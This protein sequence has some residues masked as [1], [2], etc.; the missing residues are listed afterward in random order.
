MNLFNANNVQVRDAGSMEPPVTRD[1]LKHEAIQDEF[2]FLIR[3]PDTIESAFAEGFRVDAIACELLA[4]LADSRKPSVY[5]AVAKRIETAV[6]A[7][8]WEMA[9]AKVEGRE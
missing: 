4:E 3:D 5:E 6:R 2:E 9:K 8:V 7:A 1:D